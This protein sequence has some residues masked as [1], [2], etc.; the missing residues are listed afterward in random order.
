MPVGKLDRLSGQDLRIVEDMIDRLL[1]EWRI[2]RNL[3]L[4]AV[5]SIRY[6]WVVFEVCCGCECRPAGP[7]TK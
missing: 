1:D 2:E 5:R 4:I 3:V 7:K 6:C